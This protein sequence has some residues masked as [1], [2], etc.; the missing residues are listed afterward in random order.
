MEASDQQQSIYYL[1]WPSPAAALSPTAANFIQQ[2]MGSPAGPLPPIEALLPSFNSINTPIYTDLQLLGGPSTSD[3]TLAGATATTAED[4]WA[5]HSRS[6]APAAAYRKGDIAVPSVAGSLVRPSGAQQSSIADKVHT[7]TI[8]ITGDT[9]EEFSGNLTP[10]ITTG[11][12]S[13]PN[14]SAGPSS[15]SASAVLPQSHLL[16]PPPPP[17]PPPVHGH[18]GS[19]NQG[20]IPSTRTQTQERPQNPP[21]PPVQGPGG[22]GG[23]L[24]RGPIPS[25]MQM[26]ERLQNPP[27]PPVPRQSVQI[28]KRPRDPPP[29]PVQGPGGSGGNFITGPRPS[30]QKRPRD[31]PPYP[32]QEPGE[33]GGNF[34]MWPTPSMPV[35]KRQQDPPPPPVQGPGGNGGGFIT[36][37]GPAPSMQIQEKPQEHRLSEPTPQECIGGLCRLT[38]YCMNS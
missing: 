29:Y 18:G 24:N 5:S 4:P 23:N 37:P 14:V 21:P 9:A 6:T 2:G 19:F 33:S 34:I 20:P 10:A 7:V 32:V 22:D 3:L 26:Q 11:T 16:S 38:I 27:P 35:H 28:Q 15:S 17:P 36:G 25:S 13:T 31:P 12:T 30:M 1:M 8:D